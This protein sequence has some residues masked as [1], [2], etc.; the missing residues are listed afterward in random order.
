MAIALIT[1]S[2]GLIGRQLVAFLD[3]GGHEVWRLVRREPKKGENELKWSPSE[4]KINSDDIEGF[5]AI[6]HLGGAGISV[7]IT[8]PSPGKPRE[9]SHTA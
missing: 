1:G 2:S 8:G 3:T 7:L 9:A 4:G 6:I 5:D